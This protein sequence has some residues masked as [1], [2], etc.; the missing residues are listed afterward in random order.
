VEIET[1][2]RYDKA[3]DVL[4]IS[5]GNPRPGLTSEVNEGDL[6]RIDPDTNEV[7]GVTILDFKKRYL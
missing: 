4:Y 7:I 5:L 3:N 6:V 1:K 2:V